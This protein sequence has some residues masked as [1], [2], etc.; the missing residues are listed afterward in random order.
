[1]VWAAGS[2]FANVLSGFSIC[3]FLQVSSASA[4]REEQEDRDRA[5]SLC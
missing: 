4:F 2:T 3:F 1:M 5:D